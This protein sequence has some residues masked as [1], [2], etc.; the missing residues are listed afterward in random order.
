MTDAQPRAKNSS[1]RC[2]K[3]AGCVSR[4]M[5]FAICLFSLVF[6][7]F[8]C[9]LRK[10]YLRVIRPMPIQPRHQQ[11]HR[12]FLPFLPRAPRHPH[13]QRDLL[14]ILPSSMRMRNYNLFQWNVPKCRTTHIHILLIFI[15][16]TF[17]IGTD[18][19]KARDSVD[20]GG[21]LEEGDGE[22][23]IGGGG[24]EGFVC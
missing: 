13:I 7:L 5:T 11:Q 22:R 2:G 21:T 24:A 12:H 10:T 1:L 15:S 6:H 17:D 23:S 3:R 4:Q 18:V 8:L 14:P 9:T 19:G 16:L 20:A